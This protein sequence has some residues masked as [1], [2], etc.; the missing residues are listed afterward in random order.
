MQA[1]RSELWRCRDGGTQAGNPVSGKR[2]MGGE[3]P[4]I[5]GFFAARDHCIHARKRKNDEKGKKGKMKTG[6]WEEGSLLLTRVV[7]V[8][9]VLALHHHHH[10]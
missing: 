3:S 4:S 9:S 8:R 10:H 1:V 5:A 6:E 7:V 2:K